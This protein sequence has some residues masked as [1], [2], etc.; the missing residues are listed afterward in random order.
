MKAK[1]DGKLTTS[2][3]PYGADDIGATKLGNMPEY[4][5]SRQISGIGDY[6]SY[7]MTP[8]AVNV[9]HSGMSNGMAPNYMIPNYGGM[10]PKM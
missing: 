6:P 5:D 4:M 1:K 3:D 7:P 9:G 2:P 8:G 10:M